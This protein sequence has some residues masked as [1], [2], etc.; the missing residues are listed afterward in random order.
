[1]DDGTTPAVRSC[2]AG[3]CTGG[4]LADPARGLLSGLVGWAPRLGAP[5]GD[6]AGL[7]PQLRAAL[8]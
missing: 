4:N 1:M 8:G 5:G 2:A 7:D 6:L 3:P